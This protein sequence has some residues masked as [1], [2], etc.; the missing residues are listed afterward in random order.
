MAL[1]ANRTRVLVDIV[2]GALAQT[3]MG[4]LIGLPVAAV[5]TATLASLLYGV[6]PRDPVVFAEAALVL[7]VSAAL[8]AILPARRAASIDPARAL[9]SE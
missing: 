4:L 8:A 2:R 5:A 9:R 7:V 1:G 6:K 3:G